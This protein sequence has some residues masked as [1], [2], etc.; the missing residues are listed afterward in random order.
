[1]KT[2]RARDALLFGGSIAFFALVGGAAA[3]ITASGAVVPITWVVGGG[4]VGAVAYPLIGWSASRFRRLATRALPG[5]AVTGQPLRLAGGIQADTVLVATVI[6]DLQGPLAGLRDLVKQLRTAP[7]ALEGPRRESL[8]A[9]LKSGVERLMTSTAE[10]LERTSLECPEA[11]GME[12]D[13]CD[14][15]M[16]V[17]RAVASEA[18]HAMAKGIELHWERPPEQVVVRTQSLMAELIVNNFLSN[19]V[20]FSASGSTVTVVLN[21]VGGRVR[22]AVSDE[23][24]AIPDDKR[25]GVF[26]GLPD[27]ARARP[28]GGEESRGLGLFLVGQLA[29]R[30]GSLVSCEGNVRCGNTFSVTL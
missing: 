27:P 15:G 9:D 19:A 16:L 24:P 13:D 4:C 25:G 29:E 11:T 30:M 22:V 5:E 28:T 12:V 6:H 18:A 1:M 10:L 2:S 8:L 21:S 7:G 14:L 17:D 3:A 23:G 26:L 20:K